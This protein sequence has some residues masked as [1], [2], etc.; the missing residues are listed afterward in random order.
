[1]T[2]SP[3]V[4]AATLLRASARAHARDVLA[5]LS[6]TRPELLAHGLPA[7]FAAPLD[8]VE[9]RILHLAVAVEFDTPVLFEQALAWY[10][11]A[12][13]H[14]G[15]DVAWLAAGL[16]AMAEVF[17]ANL[18]TAAAAIVQRHLEAGRAALAAA[19][20]ALPT[21]LDKGTPNG[22]LACRVLLDLLEGRATAAYA[23]VR[24][25]FGDGLTVPQLHDEVLTPMQ[26]EIGRMWSMGEIQIADEHHASNVVERLLWLAEDRIAPAAP[27][28]PLVLVM[29]TGGDLHDFGVR[30]VA[31]RLAG[32]GHRVQNLGGNLPAH[33]LPGALF[34]RSYDLV[35]IGVTLA[36]NLPAMAA[37]VAAVRAALGPGVPIVTGG[38]P[39]AAA[40][41]L[42]RRLRADAG[43]AS[44]A[45]AAAVT[46]ELLRRRRGPA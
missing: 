36:L 24:D 20:L 32:A 33:D 37:A 35:A 29:G 3:A 5:R 23:R 10:K 30:M 18:P 41:E 25:A 28:A 38:R 14:R 13:H 11:V 6:E 16:A 7:T 46:A 1:M 17:A 44:A 39:F 42:H 43:A 19:P 27:T 26:T 21:A 9:V 12:L 8:D 22:M 45:A 40:P 4:F 2:A 31:Q 15:V 34:E